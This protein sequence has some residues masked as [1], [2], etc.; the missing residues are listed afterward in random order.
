MAEVIF[1]QSV[2]ADTEPAKLGASRIR[3]LKLILNKT[4][5]KLYT[6]GGEPY[7]LDSTSAEPV[8]V[9]S[10]ISANMLA[11]DAVT[12]VKISNGQVTAPKLGL[13]AVITV[14]LE[15]YT[16]GATGVTTPKLADLA[17]TGPK[18]ADLAVTG[19]K[20]ADGSVKSR[21][22]ASAS[23]VSEHLLRPKKWIRYDTITIGTNGTSLVRQFSP[24]GT[25]IGTLTD[26]GMK[27]GDC[28]G[29]RGDTPANDTTGGTGSP[30]GNGFDRANFNG[31][32]VISAV[33]P[34]TFTYLGPA[35]IGETLGDYLPA[36]AST[37]TDL[38]YPVGRSYSKATAAGKN[39][40]AAT[41]TRSGDGAVTIIA[42]GNNFIRGDRVRVLSELTPEVS[43]EWN[44]SEK[45]GDAVGIQ[46]S[47]LS[48]L[49]GIILDLD[50]LE[51]DIYVNPAIATS[52]GGNYWQACPVSVAGIENTT[53][54]STTIR[55]LYTTPFPDNQFCVLSGPISSGTAVTKGSTSVVN[56]A[57][58]T[59]ATILLENEGTATEVI[60]F[61][62]HAF[63]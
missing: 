55:V 41:A 62:F 58:K 54:A 15:D 19:P 7:S 49:T 2:P 25:V 59:G 22:L 9:A 16:S 20:L 4:L 61:S 40:S 3:D 27:V 33:T 34:N 48:V 21:K 56:S 37:G 52:T 29:V 1:K 32:F 23:V 47:V 8:E 53:T 18:L 24:T 45:I 60:G 39:Y 13:G 30:V 38:F 10:C 14:K 63:S 11:T 17:V 57:S 46:T 5:G 44:I 35:Q 12:T 51:A 36:A 42:P 28:I 43:G 6:L 26:H 50:V 31:G